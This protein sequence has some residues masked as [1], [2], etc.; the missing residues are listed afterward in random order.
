MAQW[1]CL[2]KTDEIE[3]EVTDDWMHR[4]RNLL[5]VELQEQKNKI[6]L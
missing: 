4:S 2:S 3:A 5:E 6:E 1:C